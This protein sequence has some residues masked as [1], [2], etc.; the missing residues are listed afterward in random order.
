MEIVIT[1]LIFLFLIGSIVEAYEHAREKDRL[2]QL[3]KEMKTRIGLID[4]EGDHD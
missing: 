1:V 4:E 2:R 3:E